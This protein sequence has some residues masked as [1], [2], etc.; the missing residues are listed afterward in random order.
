MADPKVQV[1]QGSTE[2]AK[3]VPSNV[4]TDTEGKPV[5]VTKAEPPTRSN[6]TPVTLKL[7]NAITVEV[8]EPEGSLLFRSL[9]IVPSDQ[10]ENAYLVGIIQ[11]LLYVV[12]VNGVKRAPVTTFLQAQ[13]LANQL[14]DGALMVLRMEL[15]KLYPVNDGTD[16][17]IAEL[18][19]ELER[20]QGTP[21]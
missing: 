12:S 3:T 14:G 2:E 5:I 19:K 20:L 16:K 6:D 13:S 18:R 21:S 11:A 17:R 15:I 4:S 9:M 7:S 1:L 10:S 8:L